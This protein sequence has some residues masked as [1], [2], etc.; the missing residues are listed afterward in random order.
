MFV[1]AV[2]MHFT[3]AFVPAA[4]LS[5]RVLL[6]LTVIVPEAVLVPPVHPPVMVTV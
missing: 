5:A 3:C 4:E 1:N 6:A 2:F